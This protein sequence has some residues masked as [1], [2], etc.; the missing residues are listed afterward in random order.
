MPVG[1]NPPTA[2][3]TDQFHLEPLGPR[4]NQASN[5]VWMSS[6]ERLQARVPLAFPLL[7]PERLQVKDGPTYR[8]IIVGG[9]LDENRQIGVVLARKQSGWFIV[10]NYSAGFGAVPLEGEGRR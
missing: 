1:F 5:A 6:M 4:H 3:P 7:R 2:L 10:G 9:D 8:T